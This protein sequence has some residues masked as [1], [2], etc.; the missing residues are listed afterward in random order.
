MQHNPDVGIPDRKP[1][2]G[3]HGGEVCAQAS[4]KGVHRGKTAG[5]DRADPTLQV[6]AAPRGE[7][8][9]NART[10]SERIVRC[11]EAAQ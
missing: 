8:L 6:T 7:R 9:A 2:P 5:L 1:Q 10:C 4:E 11:R 3:D